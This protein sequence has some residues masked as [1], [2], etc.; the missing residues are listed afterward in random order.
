MIKNYLN[1]IK[2]SNRM[3]SKG[4]LIPDCYQFK[5]KRLSDHSLAGEETLDGKTDGMWSVDFK[6][7]DLLWL[8]R[9]C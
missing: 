3:S 4:M 1:S 7:P 8:K 6:G 9:A 5:L 2:K